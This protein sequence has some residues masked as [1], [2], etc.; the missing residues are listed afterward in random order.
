VVEL[1]FLGTEA[2]FDISKAFAIGQLSEGHAQVLV[3]TEELLD[4]EVA[5]VTVDALV[6]S[7]ERKMLH[8]LRENKFSGVHSSA[9]LA[10]LRRAELFPEK[11]SSR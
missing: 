9:L 7:V 10:L 11:S 3:E 4:F 1:V 5:S 2:G 8:D 6:E